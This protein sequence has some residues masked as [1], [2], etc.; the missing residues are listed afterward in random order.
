MMGYDC[1]LEH[2]LVNTGHAVLHYGLCT[3]CF[4]CMSSIYPLTAQLSCN[5]SS[6]N[7]KQ[8]TLCQGPDGDYRPSLNLMIFTIHP[9]IQAVLSVSA[10]SIQLH[11]DVHQESALSPAKFLLCVLGIHILS[12]S[13]ETTSFSLADNLYIFNF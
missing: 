1:R 13:P 12:L 4:Q 3:V 7:S 10:N 2:L 5:M 9:H 6:W 8:K 11:T